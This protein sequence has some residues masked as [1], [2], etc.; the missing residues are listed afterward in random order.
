MQN[1]MLKVVNH[2]HKMNKAECTMSCENNNAV[3]PE[4]SFLI[5]YL[6]Y[7]NVYLISLKYLCLLLEYT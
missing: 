4:H 2:E 3:P 5:P 1:F 7:K 6:V